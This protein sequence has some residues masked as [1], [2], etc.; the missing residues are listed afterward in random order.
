MR[1]DARSP[2]DLEDHKRDN[3]ADDRIA[4]RYA[5]GNDDRA[6]DDSEGD[7]A[8]RASVVAVGDQRRTGETTTCTKANLGGDLVPDEP[9]RAGGGERPEMSE[10]LGVEEALDRLVQGD[11]G[12]DEDR[13]HHRVTGQ[14]L[15][16]KATKEEGDAERQGRKRVAEV[17]NQIGEQGNRVRN[18]E[19][20]ELRSRSETENRKAECNRLDAFARTNNRTVNE[21]V[22]MAVTV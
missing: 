21:T 6:G 8:V 5:E 9:N 13:Q 20:R 18:E 14:L 22:R 11:A 4:D 15:A 7:E 1:R 19:D 12:G 17:V 16:P 2:G 3:E 10:V